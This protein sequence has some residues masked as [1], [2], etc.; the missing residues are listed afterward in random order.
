MWNG[1]I[2]LLTIW[3]VVWKAI[4]TMAS[5]WS[6]AARW[7]TLKIFF[8]PERMFLA[9]EFTIWAIQRTTISRIVLDLQHKDCRRWWRIYHE[10]VGKGF[11][12][13]LIK[14]NLFF[15]IMC[16]NGLKKS[17]WNLKL[18]NSPFSINFIESCRKESRAN[19]AISSLGLHPT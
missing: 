7:N 16:S 10:Y 15:F 18:A 13:K 1:T 12:T 17:F 3:P 14:T 6:D 5:S 9:W 2:N 4:S 8:H 11:G 19:I